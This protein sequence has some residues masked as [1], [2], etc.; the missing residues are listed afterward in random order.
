MLGELATTNA[1]RV[2]EYKA[3]KTRY[4]Q[5]TFRRDESE[6]ATSDGWELVRENQ[7][8]DRYQKLKPHDEQIENEF[9][10][11]LYN[12]GYPNLNVGRNFQIEITSNKRVTVSK[13]IDVFAYDHETI[14]VAECKSCEKRTK[15]QLQKDLGDFVANQKPIGNTLRRFLGSDFKQKIIWFFVT[16]NVEWSQ[17]DLGSVV[18]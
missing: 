1:A 13:Q 5:R 4:D 2:T 7:N 17:H 6:Y 18:I 12:F 15:R 16:K 10:C 14:I 8:S 9:W 11:L 3:R